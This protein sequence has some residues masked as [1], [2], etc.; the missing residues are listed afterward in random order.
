MSRL[1]VLKSLH[2]LTQGD[3]YREMRGLWGIPHVAVFRCDLS[4]IFTIFVK[5]L[6]FYFEILPIDLRFLEYNQKKTLGVC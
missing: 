2:R 5:C 3:I 1:E 6:L 4:D